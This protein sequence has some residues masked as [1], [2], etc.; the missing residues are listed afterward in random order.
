MRERVCCFQVS[1]A[2]VM[3]SSLHFPLANLLCPQHTG[4]MNGGLLRTKSDVELSEGWY[5]EKGATVLF[6]LIRGEY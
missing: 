4:A 6:R 2:R 5:G 1:L 3:V